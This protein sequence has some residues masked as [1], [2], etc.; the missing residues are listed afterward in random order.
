MGILS[1]SNESLPEKINEILPNCAEDNFCSILN[2]PFENYPKNYFRN[3]TNLHQLHSVIQAP[4]EILNPI[5]E[6]NEIF[7]NF[8]YDYS[9]GRYSINSIKHRQSVYP[10]F[11]FTESENEISTSCENGCG[12]EKSCVCFNKMNLKL[13]SVVQLI[14]TAVTPHFDMFGHPIHLH[15]HHFYLMKQGYPQ[16]AQNGLA[17]CDYF[18]CIWFWFILVSFIWFKILK[19]SKS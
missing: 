12:T 14:F 7:L 16:Y 3:C 5:E 13:N 15:G 11:L 9:N 1:Y 10:P 2:C 19:F 18:A 4:T 17:V 8:R 6:I